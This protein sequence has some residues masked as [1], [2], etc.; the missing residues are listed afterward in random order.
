[1]TLD[2]ILINNSP[3]S[4]DDLKRRYHQKLTATLYKPLTLDNIENFANTAL[5]DVVSLS[6][7]VSDKY[8]AIQGTPTSA[9]NNKEAEDNAF[10]YY[11]LPNIGEILT[12]INQVKE[13]IDLSLI[14]I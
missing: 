13:E 2:S 12:S 8:K 9:P 14:H 3:E 1:M 11:E 10:N 4:W 7:E 6:K 5:A